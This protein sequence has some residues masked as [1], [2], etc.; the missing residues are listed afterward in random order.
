MFVCNNA[1]QHNCNFRAKAKYLL[2]KA[3]KKRF[4][5]TKP[6]QIV[7]KLKN[8]NNFILLLNNKLRKFLSWETVF[9]TNNLLWHETC[10]HT[11]VH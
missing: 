6:S 4:S 5:K 10:N 7:N 8:E 9:S 1:Q 11:R 2:K 3:L